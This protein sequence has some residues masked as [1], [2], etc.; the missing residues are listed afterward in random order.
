MTMGKVSHIRRCVLAGCAAVLSNAVS[1]E[2][3]SPDRELKLEELVVTAQKKKQSIQEVPASIATLGGEEIEV[4]FAGGDDVRSLANHVPGLYV[5]SSNGRIAPRFYMRGLGNID[6]D[7][8][9]SQP[10]SVVFDDVVQE[11]VILKSFPIFDVERVEVVRGPQGTLFGRNTTAGVVKFDSRKP[12]HAREGYVRANYGTYSTRNIEA[13][14][15]G[16]L[17]SDTLSGRLSLLSQNRDDWIDNRFTGENDAFG[18]YQEL[19]A[20]AQLLYEPTSTF[21]ALLNYHVRDLDGSQTAFMANVFTSGSN[22]LNQN[23]DR[24]S[25]YYNGGNN[26]TQEYQ[27]SGSSATLTWDFDGVEIISISA[28]EEADGSNTGDIDGGVAGDGPGFIPFD[29]ATIDAGDVEQLTQEVRISNTDLS[30]WE[31]QMGAYYYDSSLSVT[32]DTGFNVATVNHDNESWA[33]FA[34]NT[35]HL[36][37]ALKLGFGLRYTDDEKTLTSEGI[38]D[39]YV[40]DDQISWD[41]SL[42]YFLSDKTSL[43][44]R[45]AD[46]FRAPSI[47]GRDVAFL[48]QPSTAESETIISYEAGLKSDFLD[49]KVRVNAALFYYEIDG[50]QLSAIGG[51]TNSNRLLNADKGTGK[52]FEVDLQAV[53]TDN[54]KITTGLSYNET[55]IKDRNLFTAVCGSQQCTPTDPLDSNG[56]ANINGNPFPGAPETSFNLTFRYQVPTNAGGL[57]Y[58]F[59]DWVYQGEMNLAL[60]ESEEFVTDTQFEGGLRVGFEKPGQGYDIAM[61]ARNITDED[62]VKGYVDFNNNAGFVNEPR[63]IGVEASYSF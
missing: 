39:V 17:I 23:Y 20:R 50:F 47:Q 63:V 57:W 62:N 38:D 46:G 60:Y 26:N 40:Q 6:F 9:A 51:A 42:N 18:G 36:S 54:I 35:L 27:G 10:V 61:F 34:H 7:L 33:V 55:E 31:W 13:A 14:A 16:T 8:A 56:N 15:G 30:F 37:D 48:G 49:S 19:A 28:Y 12:T 45:I 41:L 52:G 4:I 2:Q 29:S 25:V 58:V 59:T 24:D 3:T 32:N 43:F 44:T 53:P 1:A 5:E 21:S 22:D 11:N